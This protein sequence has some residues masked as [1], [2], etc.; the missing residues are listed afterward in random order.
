LPIS[1]SRSAA[2][3]R[4]TGTTPFDQRRLHAA[5]FDE[6]RR[7]IR[8]EEP[9]RPSLRLSTLAQTITMDAANRRSD[10]R[11]R[12]TTL[13]GDLDWIV[14]KALEKDR[15]RRYDTAADLA[16]DVQRYLDQ[17]PVVARPPSQWYRFRKFVRR[18]RVTFTAASL[19]LAALIV[20]TSVST[21]QAVRATRARAEA[22]GLRQEAVEFA[23]RL[24]E[25]NV[26]LDSARANAHEERFSLALAQFTKATELQ[27]DHYLTWSG[28]G[29][30]Y[31]QRGAWRA[32]AGDFA[33]ALKLGA[34]ANNPGWWGVPQLCVYA[35]DNDAYRTVC[36]TLREQLEQSDDPA[37][38]SYAVRSLLIG[39]DRGAGDARTLADRVERLLATQP[40]GIGPPFPGSPPFP[41]R[42]PDHEPPG[43]RPPPGREPPW[44]RGLPAE[45]L[46]YAAGL[47]HFRAG[48][49]EPAVQR[50][51]QAAD[52]GLRFP[53]GRAAL[54]LL[55]M[56][57]HG[58][59]QDAEAEHALTEARQALDEWT[60]ALS[61][62]GLEKLPVPWLDP[63]ECHILFCE[64]SSRI[65]GSEPPDRDRLDQIEQRSLAAMRSQ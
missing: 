50:L 10:P 18:N 37:L 35:G 34:P 29:S 24:K 61:E 52:A 46:W 20:G 11:L 22:E 15:K 17:Q 32:A 30:F 6:L 49:F 3:L 39:Q 42:P 63:L 12:A 57:H 26:L 54:P 44:R 41:P 13:R 23:N 64:A 48:D 21:W 19:V 65:R 47:A 25:D 58:L 55:A 7:I 59:G 16:S 9:P 60:S 53:S 2:G 62:G 43:N 27:P 14:M 28:R 45:F 1:S 33:K 56:A 51:R 31:I 36:R 40:H 8:E 38:V 4:L 5:S